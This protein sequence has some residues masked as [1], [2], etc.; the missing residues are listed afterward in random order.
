MSFWEYGAR[1]TIYNERHSTEE[2]ETVDPPTEE[3]VKHRALVLAEK[4]L[5]T[6]SIH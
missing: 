5:A 6:G 3:W 2:D 1:L 4:G